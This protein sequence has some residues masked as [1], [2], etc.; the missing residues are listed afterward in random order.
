MRQE[1]PKK[2]KRKSTFAPC[3]FLR[4]QNIR[5]WRA[6]GAAARYCSG[7]SGAV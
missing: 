2:K 3:A 4:A 5:L 7:V 6:A 1:D